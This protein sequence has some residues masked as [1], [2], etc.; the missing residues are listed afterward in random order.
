M[1]EKNKDISFMY[2]LYQVMIMV[3]TVIGKSY[4]LE[5]MCLLKDQVLEALS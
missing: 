5:L 2:I 3:G 1:I 4:D